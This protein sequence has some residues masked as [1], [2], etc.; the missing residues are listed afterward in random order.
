ME[1]SHDRRRDRMPRDR[2]SRPSCR[3]FERA[4]CGSN[5]HFRTDERCLARLKWPDL[6]ALE[7][8]GF[9]KL[10]LSELFDWYCVAGWNGIDSS[11]G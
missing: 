8:F 10:E 4:G 5:V 7:P 3:S 11:Y 2:L 6:S 1:R 9:G